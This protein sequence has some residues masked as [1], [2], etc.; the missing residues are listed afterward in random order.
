MENQTKYVA[1]YRVSTKKQGAN[2]LGIEAQKKT[3]L[4]FVKTEKNILCEFIEVESGKNVNRK[5]LE[6][7]LLYAKENK[8]TLIVAKLDRLARN[9]EFIFKLKDS[10]IEFK[11][12]DLSDFNTLTI[13][14]FATMAQY[15]RELI[16]KRTKDAL[17][18]KKSQLAKE[19][20][21]L[22]SKGK[23]NLIK[24]NATEKSVKVRMLNAKEAKENIQAMELISVYRE[25]GFTL[26]KIADKL[27]ENGYKTRRGK[28]F[29]TGQIQMFL[30]RA[31][32]E[33]E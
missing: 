24:G 12:C 22:G 26:Q 5:E 13:G 4:D 3:V 31:A 30:K 21:I 1:Y 9:V 19:G 10:G 17:Q 8:A 28:S 29:T 7:A 6:K 15:E 20:R 27:N 23:E 11:A 32:N 33:K 16:S 2:G 25:K 18:V 14:I